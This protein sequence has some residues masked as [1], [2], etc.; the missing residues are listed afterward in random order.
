MPAT[1][2][3]LRASYVTWLDTR[4]TGVPEV[5]QLQQYVARELNQPYWVNTEL[6]STAQ[7]ERYRTTYAPYQTII[8]GFHGATSVAD[9]ARG[10]CAKWKTAL[11]PD[12]L[13]VWTFSDHD[14]SKSESY[15]AYIN[16]SMAEIRAVCND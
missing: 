8:T 16:G 10:M 12:R 14:L 7:I 3:N 5:Q 11:Q 2:C 9:W 1:G 4:F 13:G 15:R 6:Y